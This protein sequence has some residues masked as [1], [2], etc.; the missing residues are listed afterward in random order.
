MS[1]WI[2]R[3]LGARMEFEFIVW[4]SLGQA[5]NI[6]RG[7]A[8]M[9]LQLTGSELQGS[10][11][12]VRQETLKQA[13]A[14]RKVLLVLDDCWDVAHASALNFVDDST[15]SKLLI[16]SRVRGVLE[17]GLILD[18]REPS[19]A[20]GARML[21]GAAGSDPGTPPPTEAFEIVKLCK[22]LPL[23]LGI[24]GKMIAQM[25]VEDDWTGVASML[26]EEF[27]ADEV[28]AVEDSVIR[29]S[30]QSIPA[31]LR[32]KIVRLFHSFALI[33]VSPSRPLRACSQR[34]HVAM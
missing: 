21:L 28:L 4:V 23:T 7:V 12:D 30:I 31:K 32:T 27:S 2:A 16:S 1:A 3:D 19:D 10:T 29:A 22:R 14:G 26:K 9:F 8:M 25:S 6:E 20:D 24:A 17:G 5:P 15:G 33:P 18:L 13:F 34:R 11:D